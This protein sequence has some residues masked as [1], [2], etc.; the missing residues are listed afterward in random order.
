MALT[1]T[2]SYRAEYLDLRDAFYKV[3]HII[4]ALHFFF[5]LIL[6]IEIGDNNS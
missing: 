5:F 2:V 1:V 6:L 3:S 4:P